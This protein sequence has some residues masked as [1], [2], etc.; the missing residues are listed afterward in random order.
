M[1]KKELWSNAYNTRVT[2]TKHIAANRVLLKYDGAEIFSE[3]TMSVIT[4]AA[5]SRKTFAMSLLLE[6]MFNPTNERFESDFSGNVLYFDTEQSERRIQ[7]VSKR[8]SKPDNITM[9]PI[10]QYNILERYNIIEEGIRSIQPELV[11]IDGYKE[12]VND[13]ND[14]VYATRLTNKL[15]Q[16]TTEYGCHITG[17]LHTNPDS[18]KPR[19]ALGT[20]MMNK[21]SLTAYVESKGPHSRFL[22][23]FSRDKDFKPFVFTIAEDGRPKIK[24]GYGI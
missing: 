19:G 24:E 10:R 7:M 18:K 2:P 6:Q 12:L 14:Q 13:I 9:I 23:L 1:K 5:K 11:V 4:G 22:S 16:W 17:V 21:C 3:S 15:L 8:F 20:E